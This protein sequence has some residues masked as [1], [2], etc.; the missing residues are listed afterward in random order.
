[1]SEQLKNLL[2]QVSDG[3]LDPNAAYEEL[4]QF[5]DLGFVKIDKHRKK[6]KGFPEVIYGESKT[7]AQIQRIFETM[8][9]D[10]RRH[11]SGFGAVYSATLM[12]RIGED[13]LDEDHRF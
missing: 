13:L 12:N 5:E 11:G 7:A 3:Y 4:K 1:M 2:Q 9:M 8:I 6:R 10:N